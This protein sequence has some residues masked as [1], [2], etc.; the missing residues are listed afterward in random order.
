MP[1]KDVDYHF[2]MYFFFYL[3]NCHVIT[4]TEYNGCVLKGLTESCK[5]LP[6]LEVLQQSL[7]STTDLANASGMW[8][9]V[10][11]KKTNST[12][13]NNRSNDETYSNLPKYRNKD[14]VR[15]DSPCWKSVILFLN[16]FLVDP[17]KSSMFLDTEIIQL[18]INPNQVTG[19][20]MIRILTLDRFDFKCMLV[21]Q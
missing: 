18:I 14:V 13:T 2:H 20:W 17:L 19:F 10:E 16:A 8:K 15:K 4:S 7:F 21:C 11:L 12:M 3:A 6:D 1:F 9:R 5:P